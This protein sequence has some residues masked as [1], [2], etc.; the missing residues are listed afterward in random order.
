ML[1]LLS[2]LLF[3]PLGS[4]M[5]YRIGKQTGAKHPWWAWVP[6]LHLFL[7]FEIAEVSIPRRFAFFFVPVYPLFL[8]FGMWSHVARAMKK[9]QGLAWL[10]LIPAVDLLTGY[11]IAFAKR[12]TVNT[13]E[14]FNPKKPSEASPVAPL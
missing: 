9:P 6:L 7:L 5:L 1:W 2:V 11:Y 8:W 14:P 4:P 12:T 13:W 3:W 10:M